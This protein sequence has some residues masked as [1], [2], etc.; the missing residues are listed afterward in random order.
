MR[1]KGRTATLS[2]EEPILPRKRLLTLPTLFHDHIE[3]SLSWERS[4]GT[5]FC[6]LLMEYGS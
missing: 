6:S 4:S 5:A 3:A 2:W 1:R